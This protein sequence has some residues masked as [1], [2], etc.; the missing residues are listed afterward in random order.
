[1]VPYTVSNFAM[2]L[3]TSALG[4]KIS[5]H[6]SSRAFQRFTMICLSTG[7][8]CDDLMVYTS[9][10]HYSKPNLILSGRLFPTDKN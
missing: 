1:M 9:K 6:I 8:R 4:P 3:L 2:I 5:Y 10:S 7:S